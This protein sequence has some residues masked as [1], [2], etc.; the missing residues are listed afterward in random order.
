MLA[1]VQVAP[2]KEFQVLSGHHP[3]KGTCS[4]GC[5]E[6]TKSRACKSASLHLHA[7]SEV[8]ASAMARCGDVGSA[9]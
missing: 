3:P 8:S 6:A 4:G 7:A 1:D 5:G 9:R 2:P